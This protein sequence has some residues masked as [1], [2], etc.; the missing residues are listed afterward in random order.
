MKGPIDSKLEDTDY[1][2]AETADQLD[3]P[4]GTSATKQTIRKPP[5]GKAVQRLIFFTQERGLPV[6]VQLVKTGVT[7]EQ[8]SAAPVRPPDDFHRRRAC[9]EKTSFRWL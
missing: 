7:D 5:G 8:S 2:S 4:G 1:L 6:P 3:D 9:P